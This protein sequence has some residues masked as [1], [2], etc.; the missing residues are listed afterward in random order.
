MKKTYTKLFTFTALVALLL[1]ALC[2]SAF[3]AEERYQEGNFYYT[4][5]DGE[6]T[7]VGTDEAPDGELVIPGTIGGYPVT[8]I[9]KD[10]FSREY[11]ITGVTISEGVAAIGEEAFEN[12]TGLETVSIPASVT[13]IGKDAFYGCSSIENFVVDE[14]NGFYSDDNCGVLFNKNKTELIKYT[15]GHERIS[16]TIPDTVETIKESSFSRA[17]NLKNI[18]IPDGVTSIEQFAF[19]SCFDLVSVEIPFGVE[20]I[21]RDTF[22]MCENLTTVII[23]DSVTVI[24]R[25]AFDQCCKLSNV[26]IPDSLKSIGAAAFQSCNLTSIAIPSGVESIGNY[27]FCANPLTEVII[28]E[29]VKSIGASA[30]EWCEDLESVKIPNSVTEIGWYAFGYSIEDL[31]ESEGTYIYKTE[32]FTVIGG[33]CSAAHRYAKE[34]DLEFTDDNSN[35]HSFTTV[36]EKATFEKDGSKVASCECGETKTEAYP[37]AASVTL[38]TEKYVY[39]GK[40]RTPKVTVKDREGKVLAKNVDYKLSVASKRSG[41]GRY[42]VKVTLIGNYEGT[43]N[44]FFYILPGV[45][46]EVKASAQTASS[47]KLSWKAVDGAKGYKVYRYS[48]SRKA[49]VL[50]GTTATTSI[51]VSKLLAGTKYTFRVVAY[52]ETAAG[53]PYDSAKYAL[54]KTATCTETP[55]VKLSSPSKGKVKITW[56]EVSGET[57]YQVWYS[58][59]ENGTYKKLSNFAAN[60]N[61][62][63]VSG[64]TRGKTYF[65]KV[66]T[67]KATDSGYVY[68][69]FS[70]V[71]SIK[72]K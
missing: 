17:Y 47:V 15:T 45:T 31:G 68:S 42:T 36:S 60:E 20:V 34:Y 11:G 30:F 8:A 48:P 2:F 37:A 25:A 49:Y 14:N 57:G 32:G 64:L 66:R 58:T 56:S 3:A 10:A 22:L 33:E 53:K 23:P 50:A 12:C 41:I 13:S 65:F 61:D 69:P 55:A 54:I 67:Y 9:G 46:S 44:V 28:A 62:A 18:T 71:K 29:G 7:I 72:V 21:E 24:E 40:N 16:Y 43:K 51:T 1:A 39:N 38:S 19:S 52:G 27:A 5:T 59:S 35:D 6:A 63:V 4:V 26:T 70:A